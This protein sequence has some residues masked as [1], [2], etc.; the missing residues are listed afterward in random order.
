MRKEITRRRL[1]SLMKELARNAP[2]RGSYRVYFVGGGTA[3]YL[4]WRRSSIDVDLYSDQDV[5]FRN[6]QEIKERLN[7]NIEFARPEDFVPPLKGTTNRHVFIDTVGAIT[8]YHYDPYAQLLSKV[9]RGF[10][11]DL[12][13][14]REFISSGIVDPRK[15]RSLVAAIPDSAYARY[16]S[17]SRG[18]IENAIETFLMEKS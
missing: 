17:V 8:F 3:V 14:A 2:R 13:D 16:P 9:V 7:I 5:V 10:Q 15:L 18:G 11:R 12:D 6:I 1:G 4:G